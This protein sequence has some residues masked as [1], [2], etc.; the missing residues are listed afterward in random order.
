MYLAKCQVK[1]LIRVKEYAIEFADVRHHVPSAFETSGGFW[2]VRAGRNLAKPHYSVGPKQIGCYGFHF[3]MSGRLLLCFE[4][5]QVELQEND[6]FCLFPQ[7]TYEYRCLPGEPLRMI[8]LTMDGPQ[9]RHIP[10][11]IGLSPETPYVRGG[12]RPLVRKAL[13]GVENAISPE[14]RGRLALIT[15][16]HLLFEQLA[17]AGPTPSTEI[18]RS[19]EWVE[20]A[21]H[22][23]KLHFTE[24]LRVDAVAGMFGIHRSHFSQAFAHNVGVSP[25]QY[26]QALRIERAQELLQ[27]SSLSIGEIALSVG[28]PDLYAFSRAFKKQVGCSPSDYRKRMVPVSRV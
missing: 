25:Q 23:F 7:M 2:L 10:A 11:M 1:V 22:F 16:L 8:W 6:L 13:C 27:E 9:M 5:K 19:M 12:I 4:N 24:A 17:Q 28:Y 21:K 15:R 3:I 20:E 18:T 14:N 26:M